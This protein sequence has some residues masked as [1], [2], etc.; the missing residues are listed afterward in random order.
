ML[1]AVH[2]FYKTHIRRA[3]DLPMRLSARSVEALQQGAHQVWA[4][5]VTA[6]DGE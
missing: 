4:W 5:K 2:N 6:D 1:I 3:R